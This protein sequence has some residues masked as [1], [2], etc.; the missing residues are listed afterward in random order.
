M[1]TKWLVCCDCGLNKPAGAFNWNSR[2]RC[3]YDYCKT[4][5]IRRKL[6]RPPVRRARWNKQNLALSIL[7]RK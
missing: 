3:L 2:K 4:C 5:G 1:N 6:A 7:G